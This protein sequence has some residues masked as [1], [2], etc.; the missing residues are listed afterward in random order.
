LAHGVLRYWTVA[1]TRWREESRAAHHV[2]RQGF[3]FYLPMT[4]EPIA[5][6]DAERR[7]LLFPG[8][9]F[10]RLRAGWE[11]L[12]STRGIAHL[13]MCPLSLDDPDRIPARLRDDEV[14]RLRSMEDAD[15]TV[16]LLPPLADGSSVLVGDVGGA[17][18][19]I[20]GIVA[21]TSARG[22][23]A[24]LLQMLGRQVRREFSRSALRAA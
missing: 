20:S 9:I 18:D 19:G 8:F 21:G 6:G 22:R 1:A 10:V 5:G 16:R 11:S 23:V 13:F 24:V 4:Y 7:T 14:A 12:S 17:Y 3:R 15:E 2:E